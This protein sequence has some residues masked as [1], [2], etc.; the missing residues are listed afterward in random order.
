MTDPMIFKFNSFSV[1]MV[2]LPRN[3]FGCK[4]LT[5]NYLPREMAHQRFGLL[6]SEADKGGIEHKTT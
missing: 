1:V 5:H 4:V 6:R 2:F 3:D